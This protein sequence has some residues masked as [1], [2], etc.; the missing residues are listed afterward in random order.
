[1][2]EKVENKRKS[3]KTKENLEENPYKI[4]ENKK[5]KMFFSEEKII[6]IY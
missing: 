2:Q 1:M 3:T 6:Q 5:R 4:N